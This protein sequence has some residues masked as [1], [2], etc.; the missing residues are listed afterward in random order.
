MS[1]PSRVRGLKYCVNCVIYLAAY[2]VAPFTGA[3]IEIARKVGP[4]I[5]QRVAPFTGAWIEI[6]T[7]SSTAS[8]ICS[9]HPSRVR[10]LKSFI[11]AYACNDAESH[12]SRVRGLKYLWC[13]PHKCRKSV[14][15]CKFRRMF[16]V[17]PFT[18]AWIEIQKHEYMTC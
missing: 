18:G 6:Y 4:F 15:L 7:A 12:P 3:W 10:G 16:F 1:H 8:L 17:A 9:S 13:P 14:F 5:R 11:P 2:D